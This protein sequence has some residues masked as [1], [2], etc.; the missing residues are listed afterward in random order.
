MVA[1]LLGGAGPA[2][3]HATLVATTPSAGAVVDVLPER[4]VLVFDEPVSAQDGGLRVIAPG[5]GRADAGTPEEGEGGRRLAIDLEDRGRGTHTVAWR[6]L[7]ED[8]HTLQGT[9]VFSVQVETGGADVSTATPASTAA[10]GGIGRWL[11]FAGAFVAV[12]AG[13]VAW[14]VRPDDRDGLRRLVVLGSAVGALGAL[15]ALLWHVA[16]TTGK[17]PWAALGDVPSALG[18]SRS[19]SLAAL[20]VGLLVGATGLAGMGLRWRGFHALGPLLAAAS[21]VVASVAGHAWTASPRPLTIAV[22]AAHAVAAAAWI[23]GLVALL[24]L[25]RS[26][27]EGEARGAAIQRF[28]SLV[29]PL[30]LAVLLTGAASTWVQ[31]GSAD[32]LLQTGHGQL[33]LVKATG[34]AAI[35]FIG[36]ANRIRLV[37]LAER[38][39]RLLARSVAGE[40]AL[41]GLVLAATAVAVNQPPGREVVSEPFE[42]VEEA[43]G[44][45][46]QLTVDPARVGRNDLH[47]YF[48]DGADGG[49]LAVDAVEV[50]AAVGD[51]PLRRLDVEPITVDHVTVPA[52]ELPAP[53]TWRVQVTAV[54]Q[55]RPSTFTFEVA[56]R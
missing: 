53:G 20:R 42:M 51:L 55:G 2:G 12:G 26:L 27:P 41:A 48:L 38:T 31:A 33:V 25:L 49:A 8:G 14:A 37:P 23:G 43:D 19:A 52:A 34:Y 13:F 22:D 44:L 28:S 47:L 24:R 9:F 54:R 45:A 16:A 56:I 17:T 7:S 4:L 5:G 21:L 35:A 40:I 30:A 3:A 39:V 1:L 36:Y 29:G 32:G 18:T 46:A 15:L 11:A 6:V 10:V 50:T